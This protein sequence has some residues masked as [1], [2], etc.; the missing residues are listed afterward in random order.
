MLLFGALIP[1]TSLHIANFILFMF[2]FMCICDP[3]CQNESRWAFLWS[4]FNHSTDYLEQGVIGKHASAPLTSDKDFDLI[5]I[6]SGGNLI[7]KNMTPL[8]CVLA[9]LHFSQLRSPYFCNFQQYKVLEGYLTPLSRF[10]GP[11]L[12]WFAYFGRFYAN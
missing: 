11:N 5:C 1:C 2:N 3:C 12:I 7:M 8:L 6:S 10:W 9:I 4:F